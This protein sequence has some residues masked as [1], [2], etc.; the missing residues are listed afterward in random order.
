[1][2]GGHTALYAAAVRGDKAAVKVLLDAGA[3][4]D[5]SI[6]KSGEV[7]AAYS[8]HKFATEYKQRET[9]LFLFIKSI[10][11]SLGQRIS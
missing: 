8:F 10:H 3:K 5:T 11:C 4:P 1:V 2:Q 7:S 9:H 6:N